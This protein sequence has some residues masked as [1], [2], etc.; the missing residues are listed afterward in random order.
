MTR[1]ERRQLVDAAWTRYQR[2]LGLAGRNACTLLRSVQ[3]V[4]H[5]A[6]D[7]VQLLLDEST[8]DV[9]ETRAQWDEAMQLE[10]TA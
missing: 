8:A 2:A 6:A 9:L 3:R 10:V 1:D 4:P 5:G 7:L